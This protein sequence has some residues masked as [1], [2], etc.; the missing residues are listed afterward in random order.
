MDRGRQQRLAAAQSLAETFDAQI[1]G[2][3]L[4]PLPLPVASVDGAGEIQVAELFDLAKELGDTIE[5]NL[6]TP[7][8]VGQPRRASPLSRHSPPVTSRQIDLSRTLADFTQRS[9]SPSTRPVVPARIYVV[10][11]E[12]I[13]PKLDRS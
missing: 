5:A 11:S 8:R 7:C 9:R 1:I 10:T 4:N 13:L 12:K 2:L 6:T 3:F